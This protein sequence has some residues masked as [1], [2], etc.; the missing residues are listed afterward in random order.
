MH[1]YFSN[2]KGSFVFY[3]FSDDPKFQGEKEENEGR[4]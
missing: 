2:K 1:T 4:R 3:L